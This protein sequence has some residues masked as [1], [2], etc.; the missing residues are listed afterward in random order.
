VFVVLKMGAEY[1]KPTHNR[2]LLRTLF[3]EWGLAS[4][5]SYVCGDAAINVSA[6]VTVETAKS[7]NKVKMI[8]NPVVCNQRTT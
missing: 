7:K 1:S 4:T 8:S 3:G 6:G 5:Q 2:K